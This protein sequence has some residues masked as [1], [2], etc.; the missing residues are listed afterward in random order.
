MTV[1]FRGREMEHRQL[2]LNLINKIREI[3]NEVCIVEQEP[4]LEGN[5]MSILFAPKK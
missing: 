4:H 2:G 5:R 3:L 1:V